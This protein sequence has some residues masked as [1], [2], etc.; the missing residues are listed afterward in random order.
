MDL[1]KLNTFKILCETLSY[2][3]TAKKLFVTQSAISQQMKSLQY[4][5]GDDLLRKNANELTLTP[6]G[7]ALYE[8]IKNPLCDLEKLSDEKRLKKMS[9]IYKFMGP[10]SFL[11]T[12]FFPVLKMTK[13]SGEYIFDYGNSLLCNEMLLKGKTDFALTSHPLSSRLVES[14]LIFKEQMI[15]VAHPSLENKKGDSIPLVDM[16]SRLRLF[17]EWKEKNKIETYKIRLKM[18]IPSIEGMI[19]CMKTFP[20]AAIVP[21]HLVKKELQKKELIVLN[22]A[23]R[24]ENHL[25][26]SI[27]RKQSGHDVIDL[28][29]KI[30][31]HFPSVK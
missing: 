24:Y 23:R 13:C 29:E 10:Y 16:D 12:K 1:N 4:F 6:K 20:L 26:L 17:S 11:N 19:H 8:R 27:L 18:I 5:L 2:T 14:F 3:Q 31:A 9:P 25:H 21:E 22:N 30:K 28:Y 15:F 7:K